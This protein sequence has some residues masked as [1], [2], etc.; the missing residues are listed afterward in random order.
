V[1]A[2]GFFCLGGFGGADCKCLICLGLL[3]PF[4]PGFEVV[5]FVFFV[6]VVGAFVCMFVECLHNF[7]CNFVSWRRDGFLFSYS[8]PWYVR[9]YVVFN[10]CKVK[11]SLVDGLFYLPM[12]S[13]EG[14][15]DF[16]KSDTAVADKIGALN[17]WCHDG[18]AM[19]WVYATPAL[20]P[21]FALGF[22]LTFFAILAFAL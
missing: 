22:V 8:V 2:L 18:E 7:I 9:F 3:F 15:F 21:Y 20:I 19:V 11:L 17:A 12:Q 4:V 13:A 10:Y 1:F 5:G 6:F 14:K 16:R